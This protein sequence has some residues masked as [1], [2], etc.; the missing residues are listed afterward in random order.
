[1]GGAAFLGLAL[2]SGS[3]VVATLAFIS[4]L[5]HLWFLS[6]VER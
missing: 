5:C 2:I 6:F 3:K 4:H 1:M